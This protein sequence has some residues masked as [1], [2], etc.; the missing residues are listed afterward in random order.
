MLTPYPCALL[1]PHR[2][3][4]GAHH[5]HTKHQRQK[6]VTQSGVRDGHG[7][8]HSRLLCLCVFCADRVRHRQLLHQAQ[9]GLGWQEGA[10][11]PGDEG[12]PGLGVGKKRCTRELC[13][14]QQWVTC[15]PAALGR[16]DATHCLPS[17]APDCSGS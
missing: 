16:L 2:C 5:D 8:V 15:S 17:P 10:G 4:H 9:L 6:L 14:V 1:C 13:R 3:H 7:L 12:Q 11:G